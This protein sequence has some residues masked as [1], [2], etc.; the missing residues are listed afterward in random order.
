M[1]AEIAPRYDFLNH[2][3][4]LNLD[5][6]WRQRTVGSLKLPTRARVLDTCTG[7]AD[8]AV[9]L[10]RA[11]RPL[12]GMVIGCDFTPEMLRI[13]EAKRRKALLENLRLVVADSLALP[14]PAGFFDAVTVAFGIRNVCDPGAGLQEI[15]RVLKPGGTAAILEFSPPE[16]GVLRAGFE[17]YFRKVL[18]VIGRWVSG[19]TAYAYLPNSVV[20]F[21]TRGRFAQFLQECGFEDV[22]ISRLTFGVAVLH[23]A[24]KPSAALN[25]AQVLAEVVA[26][27]EERKGFGE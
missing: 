19:S 1:F 5:R 3:L 13:G 22:R 17:V 16:R 4:S 2:F 23:L 26:P 15:L 8:L 12:G 9:E 18:P 24:R 6:S 21:P 27:M 14:F 7:T 10:A 20:Q 25:P 11:L